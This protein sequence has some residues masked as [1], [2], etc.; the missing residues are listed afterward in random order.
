MY[1]A[2]K[3]NP[4]IV[5]LAV[6]EDGRGRAHVKKFMEKN[7]YTLPVALDTDGKAQFA[8]D[9]LGIPTTV[10]VKQDGSILE[11]HAGGIEFDSKEFLAKLDAWSK[12]QPAPVN[13]VPAQKS[14]L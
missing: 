10:V 6:S 11:M 12:G 14:G 9:L 5:V 3:S 2:V 13:A 4:N 8:Y 1:D 7:K